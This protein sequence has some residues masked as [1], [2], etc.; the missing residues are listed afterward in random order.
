MAGLDLAGMVDGQI[1]RPRFVRAT[2]QPDIFPPADI[3]AEHVLVVR[4]FRKRAPSAVDDG[5]LETF[6]T[7]SAVGRLIRP[8][9]L[10]PIN[11]AE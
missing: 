3:R 1:I 2:I 11:S 8:L 6:A 5:D 10:A 7:S 4:V 9:H